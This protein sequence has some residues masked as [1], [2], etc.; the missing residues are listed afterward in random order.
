MG[1]LRVGK[2]AKYLAEMGHDVRVL[3]VD[4]QIWGPSLPVE[5][6]AKNIVRTKWFDV[7]R[8]VQFLLG[9][10]QVVAAKGYEPEGR[11]PKIVKCLGHFYK[12]WINFPDGQIGWYPYAVRAGKKMLR[13]W[14]PDFI[15][16]SSSPPTTFLIARKLS[17]IFNV[18]W[19]A[20]LRDL[21]AD[22]PKMATYHSQL[23]RKI[24]A[25]IE[26]WVLSTAKGIVT[27]SEPLAVVLRE[28]FRQPISVITNGY[29]LND[30]PPP[31]S[32]K[33]DLSKLK[34]VYTGLIYPKAVDLHPLFQALTLLKQRGHAV[35]FDFYGRGNEIVER[36]A[37]SYGLAGHVKCHGVVPY[38][39][40]LQLQVNADVLLVLTCNAENEKG[41]VT[42]KFFEYLGARKPI[43]LTGCVD[44]VAAEI[45]R[46]RN[47]GLAE[48]DP[49][50]IALFLQKILIDKMTGIENQT[51]FSAIVGFSRQEQTE[52]LVEFLGKC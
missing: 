29:D 26:N 13:D 27:V 30:Y 10:R 3:T 2:T 17:H 16:A 32:V 39:E 45:I 4:Q 1:G 11:V 36:M 52:K 38:R 42:A 8:P 20:D 46:K 15:L 37:T 50:K 9:G 6:N 28:K 19:V 25:K 47:V 12:D 24:D 34:V 22:N 41:V 33:H 51:P 7:N 40:S 14:K 21:W 44:G 31:N 23:R 43:W 18:P 35:C 49:E 5:I 48:N